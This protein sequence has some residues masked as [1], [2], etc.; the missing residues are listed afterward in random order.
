MSL[1]PK[2]Y[3]FFFKFFVVIILV[4]LSEIANGQ[5]KFRLE[6]YPE[7]L[8]EIS[9]FSFLP[10]G[11][12]H[13]MI[14]NVPTDNR[15][16]NNL[17][18]ILP[19]NGTFYAF[20][21]YFF[22]VFE[23]KD[24]AWVNLF[25]GQVFGY[26]CLNKFFVADKQI[27]SLGGYGFYKRHNELITWSARDRRW[28]IVPVKNLPQ[29]YSSSIVGQKENTIISLFGTYLNESE[30]LLES[31]PNGFFVDLEMNEWHRLTVKPSNLYAEQKNF[32]MSFDL[33]NYLIFRNHSSGAVSGFYILNKETFRL[34]FLDKQAISFF[35]V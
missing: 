2:L 3:N 9:D 15:N 31:E 26:N 28:N 24:T 34:Y 11:L 12:T 25:P 10:K 14:A 29:N 30:S 1:F 6:F 35:R 20:R 7:R 16:N 23:W 5:V 27:F 4:V 17:V 22:D 8:H 18:T 21:E 13:Q 33:E 32:G 19:F